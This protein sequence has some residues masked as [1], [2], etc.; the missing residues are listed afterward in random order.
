M[1]VIVAQTKRAS[2]CAFDML[3]VG[4]FL[5][6]TENG[7]H[8]RKKTIQGTS[9]FHVRK[10]RKGTFAFRYSKGKIA[11]VNSKKI[12]RKNVDEKYRWIK[13]SKVYLLKIFIKK[14]S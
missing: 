11:E 9:P 8:S 12:E 1:F 3:I 6:L 7:D 14:D 2:T 5:C 4:V 10:G 13:M